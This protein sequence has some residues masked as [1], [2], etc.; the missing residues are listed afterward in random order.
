MKKGF[1]LET[2]P[3]TEPITI[4][5]VKLAAKIDTAADNA[6]LTRLIK[7]VREEVEDK[8]GRAIITQ[9][10]KLILDYFIAGYVELPGAPLQSVVDIITIADDA[11]ET[12]FAASNYF[13]DTGAEPGRV[14]LR[15]AG[16]WPLVFRPYAGIVIQYKCGYG[17]EASA[18]PESLKHALIEKAT[19]RYRYR[20]GLVAISALDL[21][22]NTIMGFRVIGKFLA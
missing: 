21:T 5:E 7:E 2:A 9:T 10:R 11:T 22:N 20:E 15:T 3:A 12:T 13:V 14:A 17:D 4:E 8:T 1:V 6:F 16:V 18:V 19:M